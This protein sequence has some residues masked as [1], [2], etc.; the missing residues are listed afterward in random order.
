MTDA[1]S[2]RL[3]SRPHTCG[4]TALFNALAALGQEVH[5]D[6][7]EAL[8]HTTFEGTD[9]NDMV[10]ALRRLGFRPQV[11]TSWPGLLGMLV[12]GIPVICAMAVEEP[13]DHWVTAIGALGDRV[14]VCDS[15]DSALVFT[16]EPEAWRQSWAGPEGFYGL[17]VTR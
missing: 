10:G 8:C 7:C 11:I 14:V 6:A 5:P 16:M 3:Q 15:A 13:Y 17:A 9:E 4:P 12:S 1:R 2:V